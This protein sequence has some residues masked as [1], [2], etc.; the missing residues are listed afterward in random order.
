MAGTEVSGDEKGKK[1]V[2][3]VKT[4]DDGIVGPLSYPIDEGSQYGSRVTFHLGEI[5]PPTLTGKTSA[6]DAMKKVSNSVMQ[7]G[8]EVLSDNGNENNISDFF[9]NL[10]GDFSSIFKM[11]EL[12]ISE[13]S[14]G[15]VIPLTGKAISI[16]LPVGFASTDTL[17]YES[18]QLGVLGASVQ[19]AINSGAGLGSATGKGLMDLISS[20]STT[21]GGDVAALGMTKLASKGPAELGL[22]ATAALR[23][24][25]DPNIRTLFKGV[26]VRQ[27]QFQF[28]FIAKS[29]EEAVI[30]EN[31]IK[32]FRFY[33]YPESITLGDSIGAGFKFPNPFNIKIES[34][35]SEG[36]Y[37]VFGHQILGSYLTTINTNYNASS[38][39][40]HD[41]GRPVE[42]DLSLT[43]TE[44]TTL[45]REKIKEGF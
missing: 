4:S 34:K 18:P 8:E 42:I 3:E 27:F 37:R 28:K 22:G 33:S 15:K 11:S 40:F 10:L 23:V 24:T 19:S 29:K 38:M 5:I 17:N 41:D 32:R 12:N 16:Y 1:E 45:N 39:S 44:E 31:I 9:S 13:S 25:A 2:E 7:R 26:G 35:D 36:Q 43:F 14:D 20:F 30:V 6:G 21:D